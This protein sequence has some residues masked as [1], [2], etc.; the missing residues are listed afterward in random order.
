[1]IAVKHFKDGELKDVYISTVDWLTTFELNVYPFIGASYLDGKKDFA[2]RRTLIKQYCGKKLNP[3][4]VFP[5][6]VR[7]GVI[8]WNYIR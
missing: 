5:D 6:T 8:R 3:K 1:M 7:G 2:V 4:E